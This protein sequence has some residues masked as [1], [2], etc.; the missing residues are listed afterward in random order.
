[1]LPHTTG[2]ITLFHEF[3]LLVG[4]ALHCHDGQP[5]ALAFLDVG[6]DLTG[7]GRIAEAIQEVILSL[8]EEANLQQDGFGLAEYF[9]VG[10]TEKKKKM[11][12][13]LIRIVYC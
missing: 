7:N 2:T 12:N 6:T 9:R 10:E 13:I 1:M 4:S 8:V 3:L 11:K 5:G